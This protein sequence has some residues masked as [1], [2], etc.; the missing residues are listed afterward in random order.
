MNDPKNIELS[1]QSFPEH[2]SSEMAVTFDNVGDPSF[3]DMVQKRLKLT[4]GQV[5]KKK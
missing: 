4:N 2:F 1:Y 3:V 5:G